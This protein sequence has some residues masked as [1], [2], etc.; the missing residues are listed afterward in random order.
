MYS[1]VRALILR[2]VRYKETD[3]ILTLFT[4]ENGKQ[5]VKAPGAVSKKSKI[6]AATQQLTYSELTLYERQGYRNVKEAVTLEAFQGLRKDICSF[7]LGSYF[8]ECIDTLTVENEPEAEIMQLVL[9]SLYALSNNLYDPLIIKSAFELRLI[10]LCGYTPQLLHCAS[11]GRE[12]ITEPVLSYSD[13]NLYCRKCNDD[14]RFINLSRSM[15]ESMRY[16][17][18][19]P[20]KKQFSFTIPDVELQRLSSIT[21]RYLQYHSSGN[22]STLSYWKDLYRKL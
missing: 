10:S 17:V 7:A 11:C 4:A 15:L 9:N 16:I 22:F 5:T 13:S 21:E 20:A 2:E 12:N 8:A 19:A 3:R 14:G 6:A 1:D 18:T